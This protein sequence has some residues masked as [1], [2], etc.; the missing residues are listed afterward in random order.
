[1]LTL[2]PA[3][4]STITK[5]KGLDH[6]Q[7]ETKKMLSLLPWSG[8]EQERLRMLTLQPARTSTRTRDKG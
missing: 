2:W 1:M 3:E 5:G 6:S 8:S 7:S 4:I